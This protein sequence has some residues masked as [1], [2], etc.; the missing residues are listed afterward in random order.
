LK[1]PTKSK[2]KTVS[3]IFHVVVKTGLGQEF[4]G[5]YRRDIFDP[6]LVTDPSITV[7]NVHP[8]VTP[9]AAAAGAAAA[10]PAVDEFWIYST[11]ANRQSFIEHIQIVFDDDDD[12][13]NDNDNTYTKQFDFF[14]QRPIEYVTLSPTSVQI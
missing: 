11:F 5:W 9:A 14:L 13:D 2:S 10:M 12:D 7:Y 1:S 3:V 4:I 8:A 6:R